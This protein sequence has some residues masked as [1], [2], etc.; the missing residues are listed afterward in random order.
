[1]Q[2]QQTP[3]AAATQNVTDE[4]PSQPPQ[5]AIDPKTGLPLTPAEVREQEIDKYDPMKRAAKPASDAT[6]LS[7]RDDSTANPNERTAPRAGSAAESGSP[8]ESDAAPVATSLSANKPSVDSLTDST[9]GADY[10]GPSVL[11]R[12][13]TLSRPMIPRDLKWQVSLGVTYSWDFGQ[14]PNFTG[15]NESYPSSIAQSRSANWGL[16]GMH[17][18][19]HDRVGVSYTG[20]YSQY[21]VG[22]LTGFNHTLNLDYSHRFSRRLTFQFVESAQDL[23][24]NYSLE[25]PALEPGSSVANINLATSPNVQLLENTV[26]QTTST[27]SMTFQQ[28]HRLS[29]NVSTTYFEIGRTG[30]GLV[31]MTGQQIGADVNYRWSRKMTVGA[32]YSYTNYQYSHNILQSDASS[33][34]LIYSYAISPRVQLRTRIGATNIES[35]GYASVP[36]SPDLAAILGEGSTIINAYTHNW[37]SDISVELVKSFRRSRAAS[38]A[39]AR[40][41]SPGNGVLLASVQQSISAGYTMNLFRR[42]LPVSAGFVYSTL[43]ATTQGNLGHY[44]SDTVYLSASRSIGH[45]VSS[46]FRIDYHRYDISGSPLLQHDLR[47]SVGLSWSPPESVL[48]NARF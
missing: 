39:Y 22:N 38:L 24:Q 18:W 45:G 11:S 43:E 3:A 31:G 33:Q 17:V 16:N 20:N 27:A 42:R 23:S 14:V 25:N 40:G 2:G 30:Q 15:V 47:I 29:Y 37:I 34:G 36:L 1:M 8:A 46:T 28:T 19:K 6:P 12:S 44:D 41:E 13:Y 32:Y 26:R 21:S 4:A 10:T 35:L 7:G 5:A 9:D 48:N